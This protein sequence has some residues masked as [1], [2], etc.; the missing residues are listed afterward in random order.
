MQQ[1]LESYQTQIDYLKGKIQRL[2]Q[3]ISSNQNQKQFENLF[4]E[5]I[6]NYVQNHRNQIDQMKKRLEAIENN[7]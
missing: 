7:K 6:H 1:Q 3:F 2:Q 4:M 5:N